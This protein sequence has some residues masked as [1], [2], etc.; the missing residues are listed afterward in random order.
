MNKAKPKK[1]KTKT[2]TL[3][4]FRAELESEAMKRCE[5]QAETIRKLT[6]ENNALRERV[7]VQTEYINGIKNRERNP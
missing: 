7:E 5:A 3:E 4:G 1:E 2:Y 6:Q